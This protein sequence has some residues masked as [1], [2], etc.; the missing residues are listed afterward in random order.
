MGYTVNQVRHLY[1]VKAVKDTKAA[2]TTAGDIY[3]ATAG[4]GNNK[5]MYFQ[6]YT[7]DGIVSS[8]TIQVKNLLYKKKTL[9]ANMAIKPKIHTIT[10][11]TGNLEGEYIIKL[12]FRN[13]IGMGDDNVTVKYG[14]AKGTAA[15]DNKAI[16]KEL[17][18]SLQKNL[19]DM[20]VLAKVEYVSTTNTIKI[21]EEVQPWVKGK[22][23]EA[24][25]PFEVSFL[26]VEVKGIETEEWASEAITEGTALVNGKKIAD[27]EYFCM[28]ARGDYYRGMGYPNTIETKYL[29]DETQNYDVLDLHYAYVGANESVQKSEKDIT[30][31][32]S[33][34]NITTL[35]SKITAAISDAASTMEE[36]F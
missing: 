32:G 27:L 20:N 5:V 21:T 6:Y 17:A 2:L 9:A 13:Y 1:V 14:M 24:V 23:A 10:V 7:P 28:G 8:D 11:A 33:T 30:F 16:A 35:E 19:K 34:S 25:I 18:E 4:E 26:P 36:D 3:V 12:T 29:V 31:A 15:K 22:M